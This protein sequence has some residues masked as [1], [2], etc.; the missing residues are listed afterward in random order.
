MT[1]YLQTMT[2]E[3]PNSPRTF[4]GL[5]PA[6]ICPPN[7][8]AEEDAPFIILKTPTNAIIVWWDSGMIYKT[9]PDGT[10]KAWSPKISQPDAI[11]ACMNP[12]NKSSYFQYQ[13]DGSLS[14]H[15]N[16]H[17]YYW[18]SSIKG[19][20]EVGTQV[21]GYDYDDKTYNEEELESMGCHLCKDTSF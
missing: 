9:E 19:T 2:I 18:S 11:K 14:A 21:L 12:S 7:L 13:T 20:P 3:F 15:L 10:T 1:T 8:K 17:N 6:P 4:F 16:G 5:E